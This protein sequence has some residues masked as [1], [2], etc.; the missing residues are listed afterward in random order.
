MGFLSLKNKVVFDDYLR[1]LSVSEE[2]DNL[3]NEIYDLKTRILQLEENI[4]WTE[5]RDDI[6]LNI[7]NLKR[8]IDI[9]DS[10]RVNEY[11]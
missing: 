2:I 4:S 8:K 10:R 9:I 1:K 11:V 6:T 5:Q 3:K 7:E